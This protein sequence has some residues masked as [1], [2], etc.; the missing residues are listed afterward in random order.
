[1]AR[2]QNS[3]EEPR[4]PGGG[5]P[6]P[7]WPAS[8][9][10]AKGAAA[11][12]GIPGVGIFFSMVG[13]SAIAREAGFDLSMA[14]TTSFLVWGMPG[15]VAM[16]SLHAAGASLFVVFTGVALANMRMLM[17]SVSGVEMLGLNKPTVPFWRKLLLMQMLAITAWVQIGM[18]EGLLERQRLQR[19]YIGFASTIYVL[20]MA[21]TLVGYFLSDW[22]NEQVLLAVL[23]MTPLF[24]LLM[25]INARRHLNRFAGVAGGS[26]CPVLF[27]LIGEW[28]VLVGGVGA[29]TAV[30][31]AHLLH[32]GGRPG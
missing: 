29:G 14:M 2:K 3:L 4:Q 21:G 9:D 5:K 28:S 19:Y 6:E 1:M 17:M 13:F 7:S 22:V 18:F 10:R 31:L 20:G 11:G 12:L 8:S 16:A 32:G 30:V 15:Q 23:T 25:V 24:I 27:P 26:L